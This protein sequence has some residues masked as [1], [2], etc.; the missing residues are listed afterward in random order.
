MARQVIL[1]TAPASPGRGKPCSEPPGADGSVRNTGVVA[2]EHAAEILQYVC[3]FSGGPLAGQ[4]VVLSGPT[5]PRLAE[6]CEDG[7]GNA[8]VVVF[9]EP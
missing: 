4:L 1:V 2:F 3:H 6:S 8:G 9:L 5:P 7:R